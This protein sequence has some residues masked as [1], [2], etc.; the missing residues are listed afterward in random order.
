MLNRCADPKARLK[1]NKIDRW[2]D[3]RQA[4]GWM[5]EL[6]DK[7]WADGKDFFFLITQIDGARCLNSLI[8]GV[9][10]GQMDV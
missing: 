5:N 10:D 2:R 3:D 1:I 9:M 6:M 4:E 8:Y 7:C